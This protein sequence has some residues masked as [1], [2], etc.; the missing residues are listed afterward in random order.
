MGPL[1]KKSARK[2][3]T[4]SAETIQAQRWAVLIKSPKLSALFVAELVVVTTSNKV[5]PKL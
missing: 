4:A 3:R 5:S 1:S 2:R